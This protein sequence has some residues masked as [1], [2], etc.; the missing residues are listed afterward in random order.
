MQEKIKKR[1]Q[2]H[3]ESPKNE[4]DIVIGFD[5][6]T[7][8][9]KIVLRDFQG[10][11]AF[12]IPFDG[13][14]S[15]F[16]RYLLP[17]KI[18][19]DSDGSISLGSGK[20]EIDGLKVSLIHQPTGKLFE[21]VGTKTVATSL[22]LSVAFIGLVLIHT[23]NWF[24]KTK[25]LEYQHIHIN[26][27]LN[28]GM[29]SR[30]YDDKLLCAILKRAALA[31]WNLSLLNRD[32]LFLSDIKKAIEVSDSQIKEND[33]NIKKEQIHPDYVNPIPE[34]IAEVI[35][36]VRSPMRKNGMYLIV[37]V[38]ARTLDV[39]TFILHEGEGED[40]YSILTAEVEILGAFILHQNR[41]D[42]CKKIIEQKLFKL[43]S[44]CD[45]ISPLPETERYL[46]KPTNEDKQVFEKADEI[47]SDNCSKVIRKVLK[48]TKDCRNPYSP[49]W[50][51]RFPVF[52]CGGGAQLSIYQSLFVDIEKKLRNSK[53]SLTFN[54]HNLPLP[55]DFK[56]N[57]TLFNRM[58][59]GYGLSFPRF[60]FG[61][62][63]PPDQI[64]DL[65]FSIKTKD[66]DKWYVDK[67]MV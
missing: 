38:G 19:I 61:D 65:V 5:F 52:L 6:G 24:K 29:S 47:F 9:T 60:D 17:T 8:C 37:D 7:S 33:F 63:I 51:N 58:A 10:K 20:N 41:I 66:I 67:D 12:A 56:N 44:I 53:Y 40:R 50:D 18:Y 42:V 23:C 64:E 46:P 36:Y 2:V 62:V 39:S 54:R 48:V 15:Q 49:A 55:R 21:D 4:R 34:I 31:G 13:I 11:E 35:G 28:I 45:G 30:S 32:R 43:I 1:W 26:W 3:N 16:N 25:S 59:V 27:Q 57:D 22:D 14:A